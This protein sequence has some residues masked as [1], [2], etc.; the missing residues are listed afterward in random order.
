MFE[1]RPRRRRT[2]LSDNAWV[3][4]STDDLAA[5]GPLDVLLEAD[6]VFTELSR[7]LVVKGVVWVRLQEQ[8]NQSHN[9]VADIK[10]GFPVS[11]QDVE[12]DISVGVDVWVVNGSVT[13]DNGWLVGVLRRHA[14]CKVVAATDPDRVLFAR[15]IHG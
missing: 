9:D 1:S 10:D 13:V 6:W 14:N 8:E 12:A 4:Y 5:K 2:L 11:S 15:Q 3:P 7:R